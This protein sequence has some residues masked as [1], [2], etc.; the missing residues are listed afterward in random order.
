MI[1]FQLGKELKGEAKIEILDAKGNVIAKANGKAKPDAKDED[2]DKDD[3]EDDAEAEAEAGT[4]AG[5][6]RFVWDLTHDGATVIPGAAVDSGSAGPRVPVAP[7]DVHREADRR[8]ADAGRRRW[9]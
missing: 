8:R 9:R 3:D 6:N 2:D 5:L 7:G 4:E 1:W